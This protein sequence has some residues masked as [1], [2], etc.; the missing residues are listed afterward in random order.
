MGEVR[1]L[2]QAKL[3]Y[4]DLTGYLGPCTITAGEVLGLYLRMTAQNVLASNLLNAI[5]LNILH[6][7][8]NTR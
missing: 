4:Y 5:E 3:F 1:I 7:T 6:G 8:D 2:D